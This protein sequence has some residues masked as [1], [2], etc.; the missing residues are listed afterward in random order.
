[1]NVYL[2]IFFFLSNHV[3]TRFYFNF[4]RT[5]GILGNCIFRPFLEQAPT[6]HPKTRAHTHF[7]L[8]QKTGTIQNNTEQAPETTLKTRINTHF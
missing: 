4:S 2:P 8:V 6:T 5:T 7:C 3:T 1:M